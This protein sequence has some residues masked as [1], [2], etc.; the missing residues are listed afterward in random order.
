MNNVVFELHLRWKIQ[1]WFF[2][3]KERIHVKNTKNTNTNCL[4]SKTKQFKT[5]LILEK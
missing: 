2:L 3:K 4:L 1:V 5:K